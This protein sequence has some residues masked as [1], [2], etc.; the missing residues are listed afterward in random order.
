MIPRRNLNFLKRKKERKRLDAIFFVNLNFFLKQ[1]NYTSSSFEQRP[2]KPLFENEIYNL[3]ASRHWLF[4]LAY[5]HEEAFGRV[6]KQV[7]LLPFL[8]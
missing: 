1:E 8:L 7:F 2:L 4:S 6:R 3:L 5:S